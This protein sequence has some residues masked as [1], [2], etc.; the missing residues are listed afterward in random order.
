MSA[1]REIEG[2]DVE[3][4]VGLALELHRL[5]ERAVARERKQLADR[6]I[7]LFENVDHGVAHEARGPEHRNSPTLA[8]CLPL[9]M[10][11]LS[12]RVQMTGVG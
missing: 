5:A 1:L 2:L 8:H 3:H 11:H 10:S 12:R 9:V 4:R 6:E 7:A